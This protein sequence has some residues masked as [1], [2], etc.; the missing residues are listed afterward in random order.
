[1]M[2][3][4]GGCEVLSWILSGMESPLE[5]VSPQLLDSLL[6]DC[7]LLNIHVILQHCNSEILQVFIH[8]ETPQDCWCCLGLPLQ[9]S[10]RV[11]LVL[12]KVKFLPTFML[13]LC[14]LQAGW[15]RCQ[16]MYFH[17]SQHSFPLLFQYCS[18]PGKGWGVKSIVSLGLMFCWSLRQRLWM[19]QHCWFPSSSWGFSGQCWWRQWA[20]HL[21]LP[22]AWS[23][24]LKL[25]KH[26]GDS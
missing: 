14:K 26:S 19:K 3:S 21:H 10:G 9:P 11:V 6:H 18:F 24:V 17:W 20:E 5:T 23:F 1:M 25:K 13:P 8:P 4:W 12:G 15:N 7:C 2:N 16:T 22:L